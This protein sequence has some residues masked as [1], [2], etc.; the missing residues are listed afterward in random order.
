MSSLTDG[1]FWCPQRVQHYHDYLQRGLPQDAF[2]TYRRA[3]IR[4]ISYAFEYL[5]Y[6]TYIIQQP[7]HA[8]VRNQLRKSFIITGCSAIES[9]L[10]MLLKGKG[11]Q[12]Q[13][14]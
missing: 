10:W 1:E 4:N 12:K 14:P 8:V 2:V 9:I 5:E 7:L 13:N 11:L 6:I 3:Y